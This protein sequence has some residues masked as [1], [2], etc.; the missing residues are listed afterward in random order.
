MTNEIT[1]HHPT[2]VDPGPFTRAVAPRSYD[3]AMK[4]CH[5]ISRTDMVPK[6]FFNKPLNILICIMMGERLGYDP[7]QSLQNIAVVNGKPMI[8][9]DEPLARVQRSAEYEWHKEDDLDTIAKTQKA[10]CTVKRK[11][12]APHSVT[13]TV[14]QAEKAKLW[15]KPG[16]WQ[17]YPE[18]MLQLRARAF[19]LR[20]QFAAALSGIF[21]KE[22]YEGEIKDAVTGEAAVRPAPDTV[23][24][25]SSP[26]LA[27]LE[28][29]LAR[30]CEA[31]DGAQLESVAD[32]AK[33]LSPSDAQAARIKFIDKRRELAKNA[34]KP[35]SRAKQL[36]ATVESDNEVKDDGWQ[37]ALED[38]K[39]S[40]EVADADADLF[41]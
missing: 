20:N 3:E 33:G 5:L 6:A 37:E 2:A 35:Q 21:V 31:Q 8:Y 40:G 17:Q 4:F 38:A 41:R 36:L 30:I 34:P 22:E 29:I 1:Q 7:F 23:L 18:R 27:S 28:D 9:G 10:T 11:G 26:S 16:P 24:P 14:S 15:G 39:K 12:S 19:A 25:G 32:D 13:F